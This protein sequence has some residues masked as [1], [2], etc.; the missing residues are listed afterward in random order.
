MWVVSQEGYFPRP[1]TPTQAVVIMLVSLLPHAIYHVF[2]DNLFAAPNL[3][4]FLRQGGHGATGTTRR[5]S[6]IFTSLVDWKTA[7]KA[8]K[9]GFF[10][11]EIRTIATS[12]N[13]V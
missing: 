2:M 6:G 8:G 7:D 5:N 13:L 11:N 9:A 1:L 12:D 10:Y 4:L 3:L